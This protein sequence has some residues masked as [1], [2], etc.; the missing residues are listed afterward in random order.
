MK[1]KTAQFEWWMLIRPICR[2]CVPST[3]TF[4]SWWSA[5]TSVSAQNDADHSAMATW[6][7]TS[8]IASITWR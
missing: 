7:D 1:A 4:L 2:T 5:F 3:V 6:S 8:A